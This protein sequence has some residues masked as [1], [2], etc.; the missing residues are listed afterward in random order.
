LNRI[1]MVLSTSDTSSS[2][3]YVIDDVINKSRC[4][5]VYNGELDESVLSQIQSVS[6]LTPL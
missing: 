6:L 4:D 3:N 2:Y 5:L 1:K